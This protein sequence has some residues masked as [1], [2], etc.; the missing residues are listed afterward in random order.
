MSRISNTGTLTIAAAPTSILG[1]AAAALSAGQWGTWTVGNTFNPDPPGSGDTIFSYAQTA[2]WDPI[3]KVIQFFGGVHGSG[4][5]NTSFIATYNDATNLWSSPLAVAGNNTLFEHGY[6]NAAVD[7]STGTLYVHNA[8]GNKDV[9]AFDQ[10]SRTFGTTFVRPSVSGAESNPMAWHPSLSGGSL[11]WGAYWGIFQ[12]TGGSWT[13]L[14][15]DGS[16]GDANPVSAYN[17][18]DGMVYFGGG[19]EVGAGAF[20]RVAGDGSITARSFPTGNDPTTW[21]AS[22]ASSRSMLLGGTGASGKMILATK[23]GDIREFDDAAN[24]W[25]GVVTT[26]PSAAWNGGVNPGGDWIGCSIPEYSCFVFFKLS[27]M[28]SVSTTAH[29][30]KR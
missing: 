26:V 21:D 2:T 25:S 1:A 7:T 20:N 30:W 24:S 10:A 28:T 18:R 3:N 4:G 19:T 17:A 22:S 6:Y 27:S 16:M 12:R 13:Q 29:I 9:R 23:G 15:S 11:L 5:A 8:F 14:S